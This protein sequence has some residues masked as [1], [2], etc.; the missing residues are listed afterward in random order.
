MIFLEEFFRDGEVVRNLNKTFI[1]LIPKCVSPVSM[2]DYRPISLC[3]V[4]YKI[5]AKT[6]T[7][8]FKHVLS[9]VISE[10]RV[11]LCR[12]GLF[13]ITPLWV[14]SVFIGLKGEGERRAQWPL[15]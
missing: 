12:V 2:S 1:A 13:R 11:L 5:I 3:N 10:T 8:R 14:L 4:I 15:N 9:G 6:I 7:N